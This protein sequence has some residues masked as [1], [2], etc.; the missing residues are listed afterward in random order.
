MKEGSVK[1]WNETKGFG[2]IKETETGKE[3]FTHATMLADRKN[4]LVAG[5]F[6]EFDIRSG[7]G[8]KEEAFNVA[9]I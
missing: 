4:V 7:K 5:E 6:V 1:F 2:F 9:K 8:G 3:Y